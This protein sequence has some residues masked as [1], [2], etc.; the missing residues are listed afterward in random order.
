[1][2]LEL[3]SKDKIKPCGECQACC[4]VMGVHEPMLEKPNYERCVHQCDT[5]CAIYGQHPAGCQ[6]FHCWWKLDKI[7]GDERRRPDKLGIIVEYNPMGD[8]IVVWEVWPGASRE[9][10]PRYVIEKLR[11]AYQGCQFLICDEEL[12]RKSR[13]EDVP[14]W[15]KEEAVR[16]AAAL[17]P[18]MEKLVDECRA[19]GGV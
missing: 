13:W 14:A 8:A 9:P 6:S 15:V 1:M 3:I 19:K 2:Q 17:V 16:K 5:G 18:Q 10:Q 11:K 4:T 12:G 7:P